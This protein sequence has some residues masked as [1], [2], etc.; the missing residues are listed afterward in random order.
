M[1]QA[2][3]QKEIVALVV[4]MVIAAVIWYGFVG[5]NRIGAAGLFQTGT[6]GPYVPLDAVDY[7]GPIQQLEKTRATE[8][9]PSGRNIFVAH[10]VATDPVTVN[11]PTKPAPPPS[12][13][14]TQPQPPAPPPKPEL[15]MKFF[16]YGSTPVGSPRRAFLQEGDDIRIVGEGDIIRNH[17]RITHIGNDSIEYEDTNTGMKNKEPLELPPPTPT[18]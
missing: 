5:K 6:G 9:K 16:G 15:G 18:Q 1:A 2:K 13:C 17:I 8:Y 7:A 14:C 11:R 4:L 10:A 3:Q 12:A